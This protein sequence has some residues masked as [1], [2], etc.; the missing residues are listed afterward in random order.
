MAQEPV[1]RAVAAYRAKDWAAAEAGFAQAF[2]STGDRRLLRARGNCFV[3][4][5]PPDL[6]R[7][8]FVAQVLGPHLRAGHH[9]PVG[10]L[11][12]DE[13]VQM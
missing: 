2:A 6:P 12:R 13:L 10:R 11:W 9:H 5:Q 4:M 3:R 1:D 7:A 8:G